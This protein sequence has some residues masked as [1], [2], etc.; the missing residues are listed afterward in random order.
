M[1]IVKGLTGIFGNSYALIA[2]AIESTTDV[3]AS[4]LVL[5]GLKYSTR[6]P[7]A[8]HPYEAVDFVGPLY[9]SARPLGGDPL[10]TIDPQTGVISGTPIAVGQF[11][12]GICVKEYRDG[13]LLSTIQRD[14][15]FNI[16]LKYMCT[17]NIDLS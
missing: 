17:L 10:V 7:D 5:L 13:E 8:N 1:A 6:P 15:Q 3:F 4:I 2:D 11:V 9:G 12:V 16:T 14:F